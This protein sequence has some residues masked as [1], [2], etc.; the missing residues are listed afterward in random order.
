V[1]GAGSGVDVR[2]GAVRHVW[3]IAATWRR[4]EGPDHDLAARFA[5]GDEAAVRGVYARFAGPILTVALGTLGKRD[6]A[7]EVVQ[8]TMLKAWRASA[9]FDPSREL[10]PWLYAIARRVAIDVYRREARVG[11]PEEL[12]DDQ[13]AVVPLSFERTWEAWEVRCA[14]DRL[15]PDEREVVRLAHYLGM[16]HTEI[17]ARLGVPLGTVKSRSSRAHK[18]L[19]ALL[20]HVVRATE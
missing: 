16:T 10:A 7:D 1:P 9:S 6:L 14:L 4:M 20:A 8:T 3:E 12:H 13:A 5:A 11:T 2:D 18:R 19:A 17:A 15:P